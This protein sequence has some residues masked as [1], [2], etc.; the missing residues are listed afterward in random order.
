MQKKAS[1][2][3]APSSPFF[4]A[5]CITLHPIHQIIQEIFWRKT[6]EAVQDYVLI[7]PPFLREDYVT[8][9]SFTK[10]SDFTF[11]GLVI[12]RANSI[13]GWKVG[14]SGFDSPFSSSQNPLSNI[15]KYFDQ[16]FS[17]VIILSKGF[18]SPNNVLLWRL[19]LPILLLL[20]SSSPPPP[21]HHH[22]H[23]NPPPQHFVIL[24][25]CG[26][27][28]LNINQTLKFATFDYFH[29]QHHNFHQY[30]HQCHPPFSSYHPDHHQQSC[31]GSRAV[32]FVLS[33]QAIISKTNQPPFVHF[34]KSRSKLDFC[35]SFL[36]ICF[37]YFF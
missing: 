7:F 6:F 26:G 31:A 22:H 3:R 5:P 24:A 36:Q 37:C 13:F 4:K 9:S 33:C 23:H 17:T 11:I 18:I 20:T 25:K 19:L 30:H 2:S 12:P 15:T 29:Q 34:C 14:N 35:K 8:N 28:L 16:H 27:K 1:P 21:P 32:P 10:F